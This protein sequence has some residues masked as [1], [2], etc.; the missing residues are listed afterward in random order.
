MQSRCAALIAW[1]ERAVFRD[2]G[3]K[4]RDSD[5]L[6][7]VKTAVGAHHVTGIVQEMIGERVSFPVSLV[8]LAEAWEKAIANRKLAREAGDPL[9]DKRREVAPENRTG[10]KS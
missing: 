9:V 1:G 2:H 3:L 4:V 7:A 8:S 5:A 6:G 10:R